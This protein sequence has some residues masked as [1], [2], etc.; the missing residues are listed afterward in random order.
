[1][2]YQNN[3]LTN[4]TDDELV[5]EETK[6]IDVLVAANG[7]EGMTAQGLYGPIL[8]QSLAI[9]EQNANAVIRAKLCLAEVRDELER[10]KL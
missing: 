5:E 9:A 3:C 8:I 2:S 7:V 6:C 4:R 10:R 1:M